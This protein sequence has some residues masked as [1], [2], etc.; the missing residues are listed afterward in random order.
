M[1]HQIEQLKEE[2]SAKDQVL[3]SHIVMR[4]S[5]TMIRVYTTVSYIACSYIHIHTN[6]LS[7]EVIN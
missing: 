5:Q 3:Y 7:S 1:G 6:S 4:I 2:I